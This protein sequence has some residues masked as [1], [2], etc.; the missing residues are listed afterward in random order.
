MLTYIRK[1]WKTMKDEDK[2]DMLRKKKE[3]DSEIR[4]VK[5]RVLIV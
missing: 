5:F 3:P 1:K 2:A 4:R